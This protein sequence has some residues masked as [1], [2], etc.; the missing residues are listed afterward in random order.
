MSPD[1]KMK[2]IAENAKLA[3]IASVFTSEISKETEDLAVIKLKF[4]NMYSQVVY[5]LKPL[6]DEIN[7]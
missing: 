6:I 7:Q 4:D 1:L 2:I 3:Y 5:T